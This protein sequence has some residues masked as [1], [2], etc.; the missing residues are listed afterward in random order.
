MTA[1]HDLPY[2]PCVGVMLINRDAKVFVG[3]R[4]D[5]HGAPEGIGQW[6]QMPQGGL[7]Q[8]E[9][10]EDAARREL[11]EETGVT[12]A[13][14]IGRSRRWY[15]Y[16]LPEGIIGSA[17]QGRYRGQT[18]LWFAARFEGEDSEIDLSPRPGHEQEFDAWRWVSHTQLPSLIVPFK[19]DVYESV[20]R[21][22][23]NLLLQSAD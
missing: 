4:A 16:D 15:N 17:W 22:F 6:W 10:P 1:T 8:G 23:E 14:I 12:T 19:R 5:R 11:E 20:V 13:R 21:E 9:D 2:R 18:Q 7:D 3:R